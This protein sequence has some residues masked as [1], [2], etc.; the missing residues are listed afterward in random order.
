MSK[1]SIVCILAL[2]GVVP[3]SA[4]AGFILGA[5]LG[6]GEQLRPSVDPAGESFM[7]HVGY[8]LGEVIR[9]ELGTVFK[10]HFVTDKPKGEKL[11]LQF[12][13]MLVID[14]PILPLYGRIVAAV[15]NVLDDVNYAFGAFIGVGGSLA[16]LGVFGEVGVVPLLNPVA[17]V[18]EGRAGV[19]YAF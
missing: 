14:P 9:L 1:W 7:L 16:G 5:S 13:P 12:R 8:G 2:L 4:H 18:L 19:F 11:D 10:S 6:Y 15:A 3:T 17:W